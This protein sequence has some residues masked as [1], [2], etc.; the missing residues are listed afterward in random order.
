MQEEKKTEKGLVQTLGRYQRF[1]IDVLLNLVGTF[2]PVAV[3]Q[4]LIYPRMASNMSSDEYGL[5]QS[6][7][8]I[9]YLTGGTLGGAL[10]TTRLVSV[11][12]YESTN[13]EGDFQP[14]FGLSQVVVMLLIPIT[15]LLLYHSS[16]AIYD[17]VLVTIIGILC[18][19][20]N[21]LEV[22]LRL[23]VD[24]RRILESKVA[25]CF[26]Y[27]AGAF[28]FRYLPL[29]ELVMI[30]GAAFQVLYFVLRT[31]IVHDSLKIT[32]LFQ[33]TFSSFAYLSLSTLM[34]KALTY[35]DKVFIY[36]LL[37]GTSVSIYYAANLLGKLVMQALEPINNVVLSYLAR[38]SKISR[39]TW[40]L[41]I[42]VGFTVCALGYLF[43]LLASNMVLELLYPQWRFE[44]MQL[45]PISTLTLCVSALTSF[46]NPFALKTVSASAQMLFN[47]SSL[48]C[49]S[50]LV[51]TL[52]P[53]FGLFGSCVA[54]LASYIMRLVIMIVL[55]NKVADSE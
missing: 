12:D 11:Y 37:G 46:L 10:S 39:S 54:L 2:I 1:V 28:L 30:F 51:F 25:L 22:G 18:C 3:L 40:K 36:P 20:Q 52:V 45:V 8:S 49:Y 13:S 17:V 34:S 55:C 43:C 9:V 33:K 5:M 48:L 6:L 14:L 7:V 50:I 27:L 41:A 42:V 32:M 15:M 53:S 31:T 23:K 24:F 44:A 4:L 19:A 47:G 38:K 29:W 35:I 21:Y 16:V 26:G